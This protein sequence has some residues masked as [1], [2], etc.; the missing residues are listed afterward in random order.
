MISFR[1]LLC[2]FL[3]GIF[4]ASASA[5][6]EI[7]VANSGGVGAFHTDGSPINP[8]LIT[9]LNFPVGLVANG[10]YLYV[11]ENNAGKID[12]F[13]P[14]GVG[15]VTTIL[16]GLDVHDA[17]FFAISGSS[18]YV[19]HF[20]ENSP[21]NTV[22]EYTTAGGTVNSALISG[23]PGPQAIAVAGTSIFV[24]NAHSNTIG[25]YT[26]SGSVLNASLVSGLHNPAGGLVIDG[27]YLYVTNFDT[28]TVGKYTTT[29][30]VVNSQL[31]TGLSQP[32]G[33]AILNSNLYVTSFG[34]GTVGVYNLDG[35]AI[36]PTLIS[37][38]NSP[39]GIVVSSVPE[40]SYQALLASGLLVMIG[41]AINRRRVS[42]PTIGQIYS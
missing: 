37:G 17:L 6:I 22:G 27:G 32:A 23:L 13:L 33:L 12:R 9:G 35:S 21:I 3:A 28:G 30:A 39:V 42:G 38:L 25:E 29:G 5:D 18:I 19:T 36:N 31:I 41:F 2:C 1:K 40:P 15:G 11:S 8:S 4:S 7:F 24:A 34:G 14:T 26:T 20:L 16:S 10:P